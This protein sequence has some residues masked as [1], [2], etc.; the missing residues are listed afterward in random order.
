MGFGE[1]LKEARERAGLSQTDL[2]KRTGLPVRSIQNWE[3]GHRCPRVQVV[4]V[5]AKAVGVPVEKLLVA[6]AK[7][8]SGTP[9]RRGKK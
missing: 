4:L 8:P 9:K 6:L 1:M 5:L 2:S 7:Q 3:Q